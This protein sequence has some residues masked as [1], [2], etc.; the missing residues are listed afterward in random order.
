MEIGRQGFYNAIVDTYSKVFPVGHACHSGPDFGKV[1]QEGH[2]ESTLA[3]C[4]NLHHH[5]AFQFPTEH[6]WKA[7][8]K[9]LREVQGIKVHIAK[10]TCYCTMYD[11]I[12]TPTAKKPE[13][14]IDKD[15]W[16]S[17]NHPA[18]V[19]LPAP[20]TRMMALWNSRT[21]ASADKKKRR[22]HEGVGV[23]RRSP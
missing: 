7:V 18:F 9:H 19:D 12:T 5:G 21:Q 22:V 8:E 16:S 2:P 17:P 14:E 3:V 13:G 23:L 6:K 10:H 1:V 20:D 11:Y 4:R 15:A